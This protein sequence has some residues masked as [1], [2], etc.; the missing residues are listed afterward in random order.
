MLLVVAL[1]GRLLPFPAMATFDDEHSSRPGASLDRR[2]QTVNVP[3]VVDATDCLPRRDG[4]APQGRT[5]GAS[6]A[7]AAARSSDALIR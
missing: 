2:C 6:A 3:A 4:S 5:P 1:A 7:G